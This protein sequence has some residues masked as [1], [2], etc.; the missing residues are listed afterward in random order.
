MAEK[1]GQKN[2]IG[3]PRSKRGGGGYYIS[4]RDICAILF[5]KDRE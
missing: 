2:E 1:W 5:D 3:P 4:A